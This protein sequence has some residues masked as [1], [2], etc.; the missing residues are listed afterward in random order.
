E[1]FGPGVFDTVRLP[2]RQIQTGAGRD[3]SGRVTG[4]EP[5][6]SREDARDFLIF[7]EVVGRAPWRNE[8]DELGH[9]LAA[10]RRINENAKPPPVAGPFGRLIFEPHDRGR[11]TRL[12]HPEC[13]EGS[14]PVL[15]RD[16]SL[17][18]SSG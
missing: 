13:S 10:D 8:S 5:S 4:P 17:L 1:R 9:L 12:R 7:V 15:R 3:R 11:K 6:C 14:A 18:R 2:P 16:P